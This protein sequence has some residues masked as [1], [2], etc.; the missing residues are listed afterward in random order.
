MGDGELTPFLRQWG[1]PPAP[2]S[3]EKRASPGFVAQL[4]DALVGQQDDPELA[5]AAGKWRSDP[6]ALQYM[7]VGYLSGVPQGFRNAISATLSIIVAGVVAAVGTVEAAA[8]TPPRPGTISTDNIFVRYMTQKRLMGLAAQIRPLMEQIDR[9]G[10]LLTGSKRVA[11][12]LAASILN[13]VKEERSKLIAAQSP[14]EF[15]KE[16]GGIAGRFGGE[17]AI[18]RAMNMAERSAGAASLS[19]K[20]PELGEEYRARIIQNPETKKAMEDLNAAVKQSQAQMDDATAAV[21]KKLS[22]TPS[23]SKAAP[24][25][26]GSSRFQMGDVGAIPEEEPIGKIFKRLE[27]PAPNPAMVKLV[28]EVR[29]LP[30]NPKWVEQFSD[31]DIELIIEKADQLVAKPDKL[32]PQQM[33]I[34]GPMLAGYIQETGIQLH[35]RFPGLQARLK[36][37]LAQDAYWDADTIQFATIH[38]MEPAKNVDQPGA[39]GTV[40]IDPS[41]QEQE[42]TDGVLLVRAK[43][44]NARAQFLI[45]TNFESKSPNNIADLFFERESGAQVA[46]Q[47]QIA[48]NLERVSNT[49]MTFDILEADGTRTSITVPAGRTAI[50]RKTTTFVLVT[51]KPIPPQYRNILTDKL[52]IKSTRIEEWAP[53]FPRGEIDGWAESLLQWAFGRKKK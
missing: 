45:S 42:L 40:T 11:D 52:G 27:E 26:P 30:R 24:E 53:P 33:K 12:A 31:G 7:A 20:L 48:R 50:S 35:P 22:E 49:D 47:G 8:E 5:R 17:I 21:N 2:V 38:N 28:G 37:E 15:G 1:D 16:L 36:A 10:D 9:D 3:R 34:R 14:Y 46:Q 19:K 41:A 18:Y 39:A 25:A 29:S 51:P 6:A 32:T 43:D 23:T 4:V 44:P 13:V